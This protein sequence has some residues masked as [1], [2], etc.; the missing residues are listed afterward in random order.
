MGDD[1][2]DLQV[3]FFLHH[4]LIVFQKVFSFSGVMIVY[5]LRVNMSVAAQKMRDDLGWTESEKG[6]VLV[7]VTVCEV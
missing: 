3:N 2:H 6:L 1:L 5:T 4:K 7:S